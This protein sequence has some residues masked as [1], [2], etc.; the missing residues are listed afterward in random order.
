MTGQIEKNLALFIDPSGELNEAKWRFL[1]WRKESGNRKGFCESR[2]PSPESR[3]I[4][5]FERRDLIGYLFFSWFAKRYGLPAFRRVLHVNDGNLSS[6]FYNDKTAVYQAFASY[7][8]PRPASLRQGL[9][10]LLPL[11]L[12]AE[13]KYVVIDQ[14]PCDGREI[15]CPDK[16]LLDGYD[17]MF[18]SNAE[19]KLLLTTAETMRSGKGV[20]VKT[21][22][23]SAYE[24][25]MKKE[26]ATMLHIA[27]VHGNWKCLPRVW[28][29]LETKSRYLITEEYI[30][31]RNLREELRS[32]ASKNEVDGICRLLDL[33][34]GWFRNY[35]SAFQGEPRSLLS[36]YEHL[37]TACSELYGTDEGARE[38]FGNARKTLEEI[39]GDHRGVVTI[40]AH[41]DLWP[42]NF[43][44]GA[45]R[46]VAVDWE[47]A[48]ANRAPLF[49]YY[50]MIISAVLEYYVG[51][52]GVPDYSR[53]FRL[54]L[55]RKDKVS[56]FAHEKLESFLTGLALA[57]ELH[58]QFIL[59]FLME[60]SVQGYLALGHQTAMDALAFDEL[61][62]F[63]RGSGKRWKLP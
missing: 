29:R 49:D 30:R 12:R 40:I 59:L 32:L 45:D 42:G 10:S 60:W 54:F 35:G 34:D 63:A 25:I 31:G 3:T 43:I 62:N 37:F 48:S 55:Q 24:Q 27:G 6:F 28:N 2:V 52:S 4:Y 17:F 1:P 23:T 13:K 47:R 58:D 20:V 39:K 56:H 5:C 19:G 18:F 33:L 53:A 36:C 11:V 57:K 7:H 22:A 61:V 41:N 16:K 15:C 51:N 44:V 21:T 9:I 38:I 8:L 14:P 26:F 46:L 50:W